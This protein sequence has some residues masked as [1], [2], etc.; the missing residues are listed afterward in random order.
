MGL[1]YRG[2]VRDLRKFAINKYGAGEIAA[3]TDSDIYNRITVEDGYAVLQ[4]LDDDEEVL[5]IRA[6]ALEELEKSGA[7]AWLLR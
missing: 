4:T 6:D 7:A 2:Q 3:M 5:L 1:S